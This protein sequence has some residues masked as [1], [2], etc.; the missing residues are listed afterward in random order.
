MYLGASPPPF[1]AGYYLLLRVRAQCMGAQWTKMDM[2]AYG[3]IKRRGRLDKSDR[4]EA[5]VFRGDARRERASGPSVYLLWTD[6]NS[7]L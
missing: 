2:T 5:R 6:R 1:E 4:R 7:E 3:N